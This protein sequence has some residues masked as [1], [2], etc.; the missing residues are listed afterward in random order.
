MASIAR[1]RVAS[2]DFWALRADAAGVGLVLL[3]CFGEST[4]SIAG[5]VMG[6]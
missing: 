6:K 4:T 1:A 5:S 2:T 3:G